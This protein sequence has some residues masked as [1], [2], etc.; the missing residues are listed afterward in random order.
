MN[1]LP[2]LGSVDPVTPEAPPTP[3]QPDE[4]TKRDEV[5]NA[6]AEIVEPIG[7]LEAQTAELNRLEG[8][9]AFLQVGNVSTDPFVEATQSVANAE[10]L[11]LAQRVA[12]ARSVQETERDLSRPE[13]RARL[14]MLAVEE[15]QSIRRSQEAGLQQLSDDMV[16]HDRI[17]YLLDETER[18]VQSDFVDDEGIG[19]YAERGVEFA[20]AEL[21]PPGVIKSNHLDPVTLINDL[22]PTIDTSLA[23]NF[24][25]GDTIKEAR[26]VFQ[27]M[28]REE[29]V[30]VAQKAARTISRIQGTLGT[31]NKFEAERLT[32]LWAGISGDLRQY[33][34]ARFFTTLEQTLNILTAGVGG[35]IV[36]T[37][38]GG[39]KA[40][41]KAAKDARAAFA[42]DVPVPKGVVP[43]SPAQILTEAAPNG[44]K[45]MI[46]GAMTDQSG[47]AAKAIGSTREQLAEEFVL[48]NGQGEPIR[49]GPAIS[50]TDDITVAATQKILRLQNQT[51]LSSS[52]EIEA[53]ADVLRSKINPELQHVQIKDSQSRI[54]RDETSGELTAEYLLTPDIGSSDFSSYSQ[55]LE[56]ATTK[57]EGSQLD[58]FQVLKYDT[59]TR[60]YLPLR[61]VTD[62]D[63]NDGGYAVLAK[64]ATQ[65]ENRS[66]VGEENVFKE[67]AN[68]T[69]V[70]DH[71]DTL[72]TFDRRIADEVSSVEL[73][74]GQVIKV[75]N[76]L[77]VPYKSLS[78][79]KR[80]RVDALI[81]KSNENAD[82]LVGRSLHDALDGDAEAIEGFKAY[83]RV[84]DTEYLVN[85]HKFRT[86]LREDGFNKEYQ[87]SGEQRVFLRETSDAQ[88]P[89]RAYN[90]QTQKMEEVGP[91]ANVYESFKPYKYQDAD[92]QTGV[93]QFITVT[94]RE[95]SPL[96]SQVLP[97]RA[98][99]VSNI[100]DAKWIV[101]K[102]TKTDTG[103]IA[104]SIVKF[105]KNSFD[106][107][108]FIADSKDRDSLELIPTRE[109]DT[110][111]L[112]TR[113][114]TELMADLELLGHTKGRSD[115]HKMDD[116]YKVNLE[117]PEEVLKR[118][119]Q[120]LSSTAGLE[121]TTRYLVNKLEK[122]YGK[123]FP[124]GK[125][126]WTPLEKPRG[127]TRT[128]EKEFKQA[129]R[130][131]RRISIM[132][133]MDDDLLSGAL[134][135]SL[136]W[137]ADHL[138]ESAINIRKNNSLSG[139]DKVKAG[140][141]ERG[142]KV[143][144]GITD[145]DVIAQIKNI[146]F[147][148][149]IVFATLRQFA[150]QSATATL[151]TGVQGAA[152]YASTG[153][154]GADLMFLATAKGSTV[155]PKLFDNTVNLYAKGKGIP[156][157]EAL[158][159]FRDFD[160]SGLL[161]SVSGHQYLEQVGI[162]GL[163]Q[164][165]KLNKIERAAAQGFEL[166]E[167][168]NLT[169][170]W[171]VIR[172]REAEKLGRTV[173]SKE[174]IRAISVEAKQVAGNMGQANK[175]G[176]QQGAL[177]M[178][179]QFQSHNTKMAQLLMPQSL[180]LTQ[181]FSMGLLSRQ[182]K[183][184]VLAF[185]SIM[186]GTGGLAAA[187]Q[188][189]DIMTSAGI[190]LDDELDSIIEEGLVG[191]GIESSFE[192]FAGDNGNFNVS[193][194]FGALS[195]LASE[196]KIGD[197]ESSTPIGAVI[198][199]AH[200]TWMGASPPIHELL[201]PSARFFD[202]HSGM[203]DV[204]DMWLN[205]VFTPGEKGI[206]QLQ[207]LAD[208]FPMLSDVMKSKVAANT[209]VWVNS[210]GDPVMEAK[211]S[212]VLANAVLGINPAGVEAVY[213]ARSLLEGD[214]KLGQK[215]KLRDIRDSGKQVARLIANNVAALNGGVLNKAQFRERMRAYN[216]AM[217]GTFDTNSQ[218][219]LYKEAMKDEAAR[220][221]EAQGTTIERGIIEN[222]MT[223]KHLQG[224][225][226]MQGMLKI[227]NSLEKSEAR[228]RA[229]ETIESW[230]GPGLL[231][232]TNRD[233][234]Q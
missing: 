59:A 163:L 219:N 74:Q 112:N 150:L 159:M 125:M 65:L 222:L 12:L 55:A 151:Y 100:L 124:D 211:W 142:S 64:Y 78:N 199:A 172:N 99:W 185:Y 80:T 32:Q 93:A 28:S 22:F 97:K 103:E 60:R 90:P 118:V 77:A 184:R 181:G 136:S 108:K 104:H 14:A 111:T 169:S 85:N 137:T 82:D 217:K 201:G 54:Y 192:A 121:N 197:G 126:P 47:D 195:G 75:L 226:S 170:A 117:N 153:K 200:Q 83:R 15:E 180:N 92:G 19:K 43:G 143:A 114:A 221:L 127:L 154:W 225:T 113:A 23:D 168:V 209:G 129:Q 167:K 123:F 147:L 49:R 73:T 36:K 2:N 40:A 9:R 89:A 88:R 39:G 189:R 69:W 198:E 48:H 202:G 1:N 122:T 131:H 44:S 35:A 51:N 52:D 87:I 138:A 105:G 208:L 218:Y 186:W 166:G 5:L 6:V 190:E 234:D 7:D 94:Q 3:Q 24:I 41:F 179:F 133:G 161:E 62:P 101:R 109:A 223:D 233:V 79:K 174:E 224:E 72:T 42:A 187:D 66:A 95:L 106:M 165:T 68:T 140:L 232:G 144:D 173:F 228:D 188:F 171:L 213:D 61:S 215:P 16:H 26:D 38:R 96:R 135:R 45:S 205:P 178:M 70:A 160:E 230:Y 81:A 8:D 4:V 53:A 176:F 182:E 116:S 145:L 86:K 63:L 175:A 141:L 206:L 67:G 193:E 216:A 128:E 212:E 120:S 134:K 21:T 220:V 155:N 164:A 130:L 102:S 57:L 71:L 152:K 50:L 46:E 162:D 91:S 84:M 196:I 110:G 146:N 10:G 207:Y 18:Q 37:A 148:Q 132:S 25:L 98:G 115:M 34:D 203:K 20:F 231:R 229:R 194:N 30:A 107:R 33:D 13:Q 191:Y 11:T 158:K 31:D 149:F 139:V 204:A 210:Q 183:A 157:E 27:D 214:S 76:E 29:Q 58:N 156:R 56:F 177:G 119:S 227:L 17:K